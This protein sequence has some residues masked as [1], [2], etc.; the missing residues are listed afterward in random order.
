MFAHLESE[1]CVTDIPELRKE[2]AK[3]PTSDPFFLE[4]RKSY[5]SKYDFHETLRFDTD[6]KTWECHECSKVFY[7]RE[8]AMK[9]TYSLEHKP[10]VFRCPDCS[11]QCAGL[12]TLFRHVEGN[13]CGETIAWGNRGWLRLLQHLESVLRDRPHPST[14]QG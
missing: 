4:G 1:E 14:M 13:S 3:C 8:G 2:A 5:V 12:S 10:D 6:E 9:H 11:F 7:S